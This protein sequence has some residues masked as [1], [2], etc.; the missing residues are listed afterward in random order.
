LISGFSRIL[1]DGNNVDSKVIVN[2]TEC[3][4][5]WVM[6]DSICNITPSFVLSN[7]LTSVH[8]FPLFI[9]MYW[10]IYL[11]KL[12]L[13]VLIRLQRIFLL[14]VLMSFTIQYQYFYWTCQHLFSKPDVVIYWSTFPILTDKSRFLINWDRNKIHLKARAI[15]SVNFCADCLPKWVQVDHLKIYELFLVCIIRNVLSYQK[16]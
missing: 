9:F 7:S 1:M 16:Q 6:N 11:S 13:R 5:N 4:Y 15:Y 12:T 14:A 3:V 10:V 2:I 8:M